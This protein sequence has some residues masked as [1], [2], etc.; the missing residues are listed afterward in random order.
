MIVA[1]KSCEPEIF[2]AMAR[3]LDL[4]W[5]ELEITTIVGSAADRDAIF[6]IMAMR[7]VTAIEEGV[8]H[9]N[10]LKI[11]ALHAIG[12]ISLGTEGRQFGAHDCTDQLT[13]RDPGTA[14]ARVQE[15]P[16]ASVGR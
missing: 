10:E 4:A 11:L 15:V 14:P 12:A 7:I 13:C 2:A 1:G 9:P 5:D 8:R 6:N 3:A 16:R